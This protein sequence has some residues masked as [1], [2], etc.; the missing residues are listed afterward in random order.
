M[1]QA[2]Q[3]LLQKVF[4]AFSCHLMALISRNKCKWPW[5]IMYS[6]DEED[7]GRTQIVAETLPAY[8]H[9]LVVV[10]LTC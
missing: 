10:H 1:E 6:L 3:T 5:V 9:W 8:Y 2:S 4:S 7:V